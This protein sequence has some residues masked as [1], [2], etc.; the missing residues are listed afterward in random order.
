MCFPLRLSLLVSV[1]GSSGSEANWNDIL[2]YE[3]RQLSLHQQVRFSSL[4]SKTYHGLDRASLSP[5]WWILLTFVVPAYTKHFN[6]FFHLFTFK[7]MKTQ[8]QKCFVEYKAEVFF[9]FFYLVVPL[10]MNSNV[11]FGISWLF[12]WHHHL[13]KLSIHQII[14][15]VI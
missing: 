3:S 7:L 2:A 9:F 11:F 8:N 10:G 5:Q 1:T 12:I 4:S 15:F 6:S 13:V 14:C